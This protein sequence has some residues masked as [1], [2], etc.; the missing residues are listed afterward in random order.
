MASLQGPL[1]PEIVL[2][3]M[4]RGDVHR[5]SRGSILIVEGAISSSLFIL[6]SGKLKVFSR[7]D[8]GREVIYNL[9]GPG[10]VF[11]EMILDGGPRSA[12]V[13]ALTEV[14]CLEIRVS[15]IREFMRQCPEFAEAL[16]FRLVERLRNSTAQ[17]RSLAFDSVF[18]RTV[19]SINMLAVSDCQHR[20]LPAS[21]TQ[22]QV[23][24]RIGATREMVNH[25]FRKLMREG[26]LVRDSR[27]GLVIAKVLPGQLQGEGASG[28]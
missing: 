4:V 27:V 9:V 3:L 23:A 16:I 14:E 13:M 11:G 12:S 5:F 25:V 8:R 2:D 24:S 26:F 1:S 20:Y 21:V 19:A 17:S 28:V 15:E 10:E 7:D 6:L 22:Q 18:A